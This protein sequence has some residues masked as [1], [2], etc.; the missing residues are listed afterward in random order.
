LVYKKEAIKEILDKLKMSY[1]D[2][3]IVEGNGTTISPSLIFLVFSPVEMKVITNN[4]TY[5]ENDGLIFI[6]NASSQTYK[7]EL[8][9]KEKGYYQ[10]LIGLVG[11][12]KDQWSKIDGQVTN[13]NP[14]LQVDKYEI[15]FNQ[16]N[17]VKPLPSF[18]LTINRLIGINVNVRDKHI[19]AAIKYLSEAKKYYNK[20]KY[21]QVKLY[22]EKAHHEIFSARKFVDQNTKNRLLEV[23]DDVESL[24]STSLKDSHIQIFEKKLKIELELFKKTL[25]FSENYLLLQKRFGKDITKKAI[26]A[27]IIDDKIRTAEDNLKS[28]NFYSCEIMERTV[29]SLIKELK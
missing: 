29:A 1:Q 8:T 7:L 22:F 25:L 16:I 18:D 5:V 14:S 15:N 12:N 3:Q 13:D 23:I 6:E 24:Y 26:L 4:N 10:V 17:P 21:L 9:G 2:N 27:K 20:R 11:N 28:K 19:A